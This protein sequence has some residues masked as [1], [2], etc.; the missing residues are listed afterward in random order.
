MRRTADVAVIGAGAA[1]LAAADRLLRAGLD[2]VVVEARPRIG[3]RV[4][5]VHPPSWPSPVEL[6]AEFIHG[7]PTAMLKLVRAARLK[8]DRVPNDHRIRTHG[9]L[10]KANAAFAAGEALVAPELSG[11]DVSWSKAIARKRREAP[12]DPLALRAA[13]G[14]VEGFY[15]ADPRHV[16]TY[17]LERMQEGAEEGGGAQMGRLVAG[18][19]TLLQHLAR[20]LSPGQLLLSAEVERTRWR[21][22]QVRLDVRGLGP[23]RFQLRARAAIFTLPLPLLVP[24]AGPRFFPALPQKARAAGAL[25]MGSVV[26]A[27]LRFRRRFWRPPGLSF[28]HGFEL[29]IPT[30]WTLAP[31]ELPIFV[32]WAGGPAAAALAGRSERAL[33]EHAVGSLAGTLGCSPATLWDELDGYLLRDWASEP[34]SRGAYMVVPPGQ[35]LLPR[36]LAEPVER[37]LFFAGE[38]THLQGQAGTVHGAMETGVRAAKELLAAR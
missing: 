1:G 29:P 26:K 6:G 37:T 3:G 28:A 9:K 30:W 31:R 35:T 23:S 7:R 11:P 2:V 15:V 25:R 19:A 18:Y 32:G 24:G 33:L 36:V 14:F 27:V 13:R 10:R 16:S 5:T 38:A 8:V 22:G 34:Y 12:V 21:R 4:E 17:F 20:R